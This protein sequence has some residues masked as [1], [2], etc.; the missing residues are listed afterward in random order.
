MKISYIQKYIYRNHWHKKW[1]FL[2]LHYF[3]ASTTT[4]GTSGRNF[5][6]QKITNVFSA[7]N[8]LQV[9]RYLLFCDGGIFSSHALTLVDAK[10]KPYVGKTLYMSLN[11]IFCL[12]CKVLINRKGPIRIGSYVQTMICF[13]I[14]ELILI[15]THQHNK[16]GM[17]KA[18]EQFTI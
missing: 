5:D 16:H 11:D 18:I 3:V 6:R 13:W 14:F 1:Y 8:Q 9:P 12:F 2:H 17:D 7:I 4:I 15:S 10:L